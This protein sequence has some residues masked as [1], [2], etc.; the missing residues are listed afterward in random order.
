METLLN[1]IT[2]NLD[3]SSEVSVK[4]FITPIEY[5]GSNFHVEWDALANLQVAESEKQYAASVFLAFLPHVP[6]SVGELWQ[7]EQ[8]GALELLKQLQ[9][10]P[11]LNLDIDAG[12]SEGL[13]ACLRAY[14]DRL[15]DIVFRIHAEF[16]LTDGW[17]TPSQFAGHLV[18]DRIEERVVFFKMHVP[19]STV[20]FDVRW[21]RDK[22]D[23]GFF[24]DSGF[25]PRMELYAGTEDVV[26]QMEFTEAISQEKA[27]HKLMYQFYEWQRIN[28]VPVDKALEIAQAQQKPIHVISIDGPLAD[29]SC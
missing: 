28:W 9:S 11:H 7:I 21:K 22:D 25:C 17:F 6:V 18:I 1:K 24:T 4:G 8:D 12:D 23:P 19:S 15:A 27:E 13:W 16:T 2:L 14:N 26:Q 5:T 3:D 10:D 29:E 20:N